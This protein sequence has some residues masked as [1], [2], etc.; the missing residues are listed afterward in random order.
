MEY[1]VNQQGFIFGETIDKGAL[2]R[3]SLSERQL[4]DNEGTFGEMINNE[5]LSER[6][7]ISKGDTY[8]ETIDKGSLSEQQSI[9]KGGIIG[10]T[11][12]YQ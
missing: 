6:Q 5:S 7:S 11:Q 3:D 8:G 4:I 2:D 10:D 12:Q 1:I 9:D